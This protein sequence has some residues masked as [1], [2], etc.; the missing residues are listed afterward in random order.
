MQTSAEMLVN[1]AQGGYIETASGKRFYID[2][3]EF[4]INDIAAATSKQCRYTGH[5]KDFYSV[6]EHQILVSEIMEH[7]ELGDPFEGCNHDDAEGYLSDIASPWKALLP[8]YKKLEA[9]VEGPLRRWLGIPEQ[10]TDGCKRADWLALFIEVKTLLPTKGADWPAPPGVKEQAQ[11]IA[12][13]FWIRCWTP[14]TAEREWLARW[15]QLNAKRSQ[16]V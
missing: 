13:K 10:M 4:D 1:H 8:D 6:A 11:E 9:K 3:P 15:K 14:V 2:A 12:S 5:T 16:P 7:L